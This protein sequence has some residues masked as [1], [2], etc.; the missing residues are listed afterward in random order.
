[1]LL[2]KR[3]ILS[4]MASNGQLALDTVRG[5]GGSAV[6]FDLVFMD[7]SMPVMVRRILGYLFIPLVVEVAVFSYV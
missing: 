5:S 4:S 3:G 2:K 7:N 6:A 1:M